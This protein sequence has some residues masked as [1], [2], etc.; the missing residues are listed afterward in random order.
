MEL[1][2]KF[3]NGLMRTDFISLYYFLLAVMNK[4]CHNLSSMLMPLITLR[5]KD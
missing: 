2:L 3:H 4:F 1:K 5:S